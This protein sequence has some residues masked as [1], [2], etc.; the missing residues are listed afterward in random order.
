MDI[1]YSLRFGHNRRHNYGTQDQWALSTTTIH[2][3]FDRSRYDSHHQSLWQRHRTVLFNYHNHVFQQPHSMSES[4]IT[5]LTLWPRLHNYDIY[6]YKYW[7]LGQ[8]IRQ[9][10]RISA[11]LEFHCD[12]NNVMLFTTRMATLCLQERLPSHSYSFRSVRDTRPIILLYPSIH[13]V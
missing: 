10:M 3:C 8:C 7:F 11:E 2:S 9:D 13:W 1:L 4:L 12:I 6:S 5:E